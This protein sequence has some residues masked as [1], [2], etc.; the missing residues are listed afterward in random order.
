[1]T[2][3]RVVIVG[4]VEWV[5][6]ALGE[7]PARGR[8]ADLH[9]AFTEPAGGGGVAAAAAARLGAP[10]RLLT[11]VGN[12]DAAASSLDLLRSRGI[13]VAA[14]RR[15]VPQTPVLT[16]TGRDGERTIMVVG[17]R[18]QAQAADGMHESALA[19]AGAAYYTGEDPALLAEVR[20]R[21]PLLVVSA[22]RSADL[23]ASG[24]A[25]DVVVGSLN[26]PDEHTDDLP[27]HLRPQWCVQTDGANGGV[28]VAIDGT[29]IRYAP[30]PP[31]GV[32]ID[33]Y[34]CGDSFAAGLTVGLSRGLAITDAA[35]LGAC[36]GAACTTWRG[37]I[38][39]T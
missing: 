11:A 6:H 4:H 35:A 9:G 16:I 38:G 18:L 23:V 2:A 28:I 13:D 3:P 31:P 21:V 17:N 30:V 37:G 20:A 33:S 5:T 10:V 15:P 25:A 32:V 8:I 29:E 26:D 22:R 1:V 27:Q 34:G 39:P 24:V 12:D 36:A 19:D 14:T 7:V